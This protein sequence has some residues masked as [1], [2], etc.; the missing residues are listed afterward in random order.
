MRLRLLCQTIGA[1]MKNAKNGPN[2]K[3]FTRFGNRISGDR[4]F[5]Q[6]FKVSVIYLICGFIWIVFS[7]WIAAF[8]FQD[9]QVL[10]TINTVKG[11]IYVLATAL[12]IFLLMHAEL[13]RV[14]RSVEEVKDANQNLAQTNLLLAASLESSPD[15]MFYSI[16]SRRK[17]TACNARYREYIRKKTGHDIRLGDDCLTPISSESEK[18]EWQSIYA[19]VFEGEYVQMSE[20]HFDAPAPSYWQAFYSPIRDEQNTVQGLTCFLSN[21]TD[22]RQAQ[23]QNTYLIYHDALTG[24]YNR[25]YYNDAVTHLESSGT[26][27]ISVIVGDINGLKTVNDALGHQA[28]DDLLKSAAHAMRDY[29]REEDIVVRWGGDEFVI[30]LPGVDTAGAA[31]TAAAI[32]HACQYNTLSAVPVNI[33]F[34]WG[35]KTSPDQDLPGIVTLAEES[36]FR[37]KI[38]ESNSSANQ[39]I[40]VIMSALHE[41]SPREEAHSRRVG[42][43]CR[44]IGVAM[45]LSEFEINTLRFVGYLHDLGKIAIDE[46]ILDKPGALSKEERESIYLHPEVGYRIIRNSC[47]LLEIAEG[48]LSH[49]ERWNGTGYP[50]GLSGTQIPRIARIIAIADSYDAMTATRP[51]RQPI[52]QDE[53][54][55]EIRRNAGILYDPDIAMLFV[56]EVLI[57]EWD[58]IPWEQDFAPR[59]PGHA[60]V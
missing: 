35:T 4:A 16:D 33:S 52:S 3:I 37:N 55:E 12:L 28:G 13:S 8:L 51:Y 59:F 14:H 9:I 38:T 6:S 45:N 18:S 57:Y 22:L 41:K 21:T 48:I 20:E 56:N 49:H 2:A 1:D 5:I 29:C 34:G 39:T 36:M 11:W 43:I 44:K 32:R 15:I 19:R 10:T 47:E 54:A 30:L 23:D 17:Y 26:L 24:L 42:E 50:R 53:A 46:H 27:P 60:D 7:D 40:L 25:R 58:L 31:K